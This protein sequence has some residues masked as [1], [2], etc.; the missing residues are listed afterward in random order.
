MPLISKFIYVV[1]FLVAASTAHA[2]APATLSLGSTPLNAKQQSPDGTLLATLPARQIGGELAN[3]PL[4]VTIA[5]QVWDE[6]RGIYKSDVPGIGFSFC[7]QE[8][9]RCLQRGTTVSGSTLEADLKDYALRLY[10]I[11]NLQGGNYSLP[12][13][14]RLSVNGTPALEIGLSALALN[15]SQCSIT[16]DKLRVTFPDA[17]LG[18][19]RLLSSVQF[20]LPIS[21]KTPEDFRNIAIHFTYNGKLADAQRL[22]TNLPGIGMSLKNEAGQYASFNAGSTE[23]ES[24]FHDTRYVAELIKL[25]NEAATAG[26]FDVAVT[27]I[28][29]LR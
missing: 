14:I 22:E 12:G 1:L 13:I 26:D 3:K 11:G 18:S 23:P 5:T 28:V 25:N 17:T 29:E 21:C 27:A 7:R 20:Q 4:L 2:A 8:G 10:K 19:Q 24:V 6:N 15:V 9:E 16:Q